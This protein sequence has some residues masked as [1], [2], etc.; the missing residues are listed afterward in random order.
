MNNLETLKKIF[1]DAKVPF[2]ILPKDDEWLQ[3]EP[4]P[5]T[6]HVMRVMPGYRCHFEVEFNIDGKLLNAGQFEDM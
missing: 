6:E 5:S 2:T 1:T 3:F 4:D